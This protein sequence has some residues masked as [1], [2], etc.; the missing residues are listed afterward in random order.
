MEKLSTKKILLVDDERIF[1]W[2]L[3]KQLGE[4]ENNYCILTAEDSHR[5]MKLLESEPVDL[6]VT[7]FKMPGTDGAEL[8]SHLKGK[9]PAIPVIVMSAHLRPEVERKLRGLGVSQFIDKS[10]LSDGSD[11]LEKMILEILKTSNL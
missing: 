2:L 4:C 10:L 8:V 7:D 1:L 3:A 5:A 9:Y 6:I 11:V